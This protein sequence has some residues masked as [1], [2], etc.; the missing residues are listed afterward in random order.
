V[1]NTIKFLIVLGSLV[2]SAPIDNWSKGEVL[3]YEIGWGFVTAG[4][5]KMQVIPRPESGSLELLATAHNNGVFESI[6]PVRDTIRSLVSAQTLLPSFFRKINNEGTW[7]NHVQIEFN[8]AKNTA[9][10]SDTVFSSPPPKAKIRRH[11]DTTVTLDPETH[12][13]MSAF[14]FIRT[15]DLVPGQTKTFNAVSG[16]KKYK[17]KVIAHRYETIKVA[18]GSFRC[19]VVEPVLA[20]DGIFKAKGK[21]TIWLTNDAQRIP[22]L[23]KSKIA[24]GSIRVELLKTN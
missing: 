23:V 2:Y 12:N 13:I 24:L 11:S 18:A 14:Y 20:D 7:H 9:R 8:H 4:T 5:A 6:Y 16:K 10:L 15:L 22:V 19:L 1:K 21:M 3:R 17:L